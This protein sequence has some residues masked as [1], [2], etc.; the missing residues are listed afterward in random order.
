MVDSNRMWTALHVPCL[1]MPFTRG[2]E[3]L[4]IGVQLI[5][6]NRADDLLLRVGQW[7]RQALTRDVILE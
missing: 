6:G 7:A 4:P 5:A 2:P 1:V 3:G